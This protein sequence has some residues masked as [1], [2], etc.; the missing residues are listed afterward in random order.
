MGGARTFFLAWALIVLIGVLRAQASEA[1]GLAALETLEVARDRSGGAA[2]ALPQ[3]LSGAQA[4]RYRRIFE[5]QEKGRWH[6]A[7]KEIARIEDPVLMGYVLAQ[8]YLHPTAYRSKYIELRDW[9]G[10][11]ADLP[12][13]QRI[14][15]LALRRRP[16]NWRYPKKPDGRALTGNGYD[17]DLTTSYRYRTTKRLSKADRRKANRLKA[18]IRARVRRGWPTGALALLDGKDAKLLDRVEIDL[19]RGQIATGYYYFGKP[20]RAFELASAAARR[21]GGKVPDA[22]WIAGLTAWRNGRFA[23]A[24]PFFTALAVAEAAGPWQRAAGGYWAARAA[25]RSG[26]VAE[27]SPMLRLAAAE[28]RTFYGL[29][30]RRALG[31]ALDLDWDRLTLTEGRARLLLENPAGRRALALLQLGQR[32]AAELALRFLARDGDETL[33]RAILALA[34][35]AQMPGLTRQLGASLA[36]ATGE[37]IVNAL[38]PVPPW[39]PEEGFSIDRAL[40]YA[41]VRQESGFNAKATSR[42]GARGLMQLMPATAS[43][44]ANR[45][46]RGAARRKLYDPELNLSLGQK[47]LDMLLAEQRIGGSLLKLLAAYN[48]GIGKLGNWEKDFDFQDDPLYFIESI[49]SPETRIFIERVMANLWIYR[50]RMG[51]AQPSLDALAEGVWPLYAAQDDRRATAQADVR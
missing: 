24:K 32:D 37:I 7:D 46:F 6:D 43:F 28:Q 13:A 15:K 35:R 18:S 29:L 39:Q 38:Y 21:S 3:P 20:K 40:V 2:V 48:G 10:V 27:V 16:K 17:F 47:Y 33:R 9:M 30:A 25:L 19:A 45:R 14:Y 50:H 49:P 31:M 11:Y 1:P 22:Q 34:D 26:A 4:A 36:Q 12:Q 44:V 8:R 42:A 5:L 41:F 51:Q 23:E